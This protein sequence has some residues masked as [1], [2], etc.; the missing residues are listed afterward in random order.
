MKPV[1]VV[2]ANDLVEASAYS[3]VLKAAEGCDGSFLVKEMETYFPGGY[4][5]MDGDRIVDIVE[6]PGTGNEP[7]KFV[8]IVVHVHNESCRQDESELL[9][10][11]LFASKM[12]WP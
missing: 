2:S 1:M 8:N 9:N 6:K 11:L 7:S 5:T 3:E 12:R 4:V 10:C